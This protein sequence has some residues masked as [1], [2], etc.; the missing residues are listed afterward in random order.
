MEGEAQYEPMFDR[1]LPFAKRACD[2]GVASA[3]HNLAVMYMRG[4]GVEKSLDW[5]K[6]YEARRNELSAK[7]PKP[8]NKLMELLKEAH[9]AT[10]G[11]KDV[12]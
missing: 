6:F 12:N 11:L 1:G 3:C 7:Q 9:E 2:M 10:A 4:D 5:H 8:S